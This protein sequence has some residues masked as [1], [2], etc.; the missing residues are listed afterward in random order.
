MALCHHLEGYLSRVPGGM[1]P[2]RALLGDDTL[3]GNLALI[4]AH[5]AALSSRLPAAGYVG[6]RLDPLLLLSSVLAIGWFEHR[7]DQRQSRFTRSQRRASLIA[8]AISFGR[9]NCRS[10]APMIDNHWC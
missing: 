9:S 4:E 1:E 2:R 7:D 10:L 3:A 5:E 8:N 6:P